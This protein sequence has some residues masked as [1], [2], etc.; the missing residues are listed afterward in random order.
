MCRKMNLPIN[1]DET[2]VLL[3]SA[4]KSGSGELSPDE[5]L[6]LIF[7]EAN[8]LNTDLPRLTALQTGDINDT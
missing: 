7:N 2:R 1:K 8:V 3:A 5:F 6:D 4:N